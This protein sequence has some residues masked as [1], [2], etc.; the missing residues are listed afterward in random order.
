[1]AVAKSV[2]T[3]GLSNQQAY[4]KFPSPATSVAYHHAFLPGRDKK[5]PF[6]SHF[7]P[8]ISPSLFFFLTELRQSKNSLE[9]SACVAGSGQMPCGT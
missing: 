9:L 1:M 6:V 8:V 3:F 7:L 5:G 4:T 2:C